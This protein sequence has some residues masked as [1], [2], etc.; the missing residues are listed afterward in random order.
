M[1]FCPLVGKVGKLPCRSFTVKS[2]TIS[3]VTAA[4]KRR[5]QARI[6]VF[7]YFLDVQVLARRVNRKVEPQ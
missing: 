7:Q 5:L 4:R 3:F 1:R 2:Q 6:Q